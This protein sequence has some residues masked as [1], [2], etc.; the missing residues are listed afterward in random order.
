MRHFSSEGFLVPAGEIA[1]D[2]LIPR[3]YDPRIDDEL[4]FLSAT[5]HL[6]RIDSLVADGH[7]KHDHGKYIPKIYYGT[8]PIPYVRTSDLANWEI[9]ASPKHGIPEEVY[10]KHKDHQDVQPEDIL[11]VHEG[12]YLIGSA[13]MVTTY[14]GPMLYQHHL[15]KF[16]VLPTAPFGPYFF[17]AAL[18]SPTVQRQLRSR[19]FTADTIDSVVGRLG[20][21]V[22]P[23]PKSTAR[24]KR[25]EGVVKK[26]ITRR[27]EI[28][29]KLTFA[30]RGIDAFLAGENNDLEAVFEGRPPGKTEGPEFLGYRKAFLAFT[31]ENGGIR[32]D[33]LIPKYYDPSIE[34]DAKKYVTLAELDS[35]DRLREQK[36]VTLK[37]GDEIDSMNYGTGNIPFM[38]TSDLA[39]WELKREAKQSVSE[40]PV[41]PTHR[42]K[43]L[44]PGGH[45]DDLVLLHCEWTLGLDRFAALRESRLA[46]GVPGDAR[47][48]ELVGEHGDRWLFRFALPTESGMRTNAVRI[49]A[50]GDG[51]VVEHLVVDEDQRPHPEPSADSPE[52]TRMIL[53]LPGVQ[54]AMLRG[55]GPVVLGEREVPALVADALEPHREAPIVLISVDNATREPLVDPPELARRLAGMARVVSLS[56][57]GASRRLKDELVGRGFSEKFGCFHGGVRIL[58]PG[59][60]QGDDPYDHLLLLP[61]R[62]YPI[63]ER[64]RTER[65][66]GLFCE[67]I[68][69]DEDLRARLREVEAPSRPEPVRPAPPRSVVARSLTTPKVGPP[70][71]GGAPSGQTPATIPWRSPLAPQRPRA[72]AASPAPNMVPPAESVPGK[73]PGPPTI[74]DDTSQKPAPLSTQNPIPEHPPG[75]TS[76]P[77]P[78]S[79]PRCPPRRLRL[80]PPAATPSPRTCCRRS[81]SSS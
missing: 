69:E 78:A 71:V 15:A 67:M 4:E 35:I 75:L 60:Q 57:V 19:Q 22:I 61:V 31:Q 9:K 24:L 39:S 8:G 10:L 49:S 50:T 27:A 63:P 7:L 28:R 52:T 5:H 55:V 79:R 81:A 11:F 20:E 40:A 58:W 1:N 33:I 30:V 34:E 42:S 41:R 68:A 65:I 74:A 66:A 32:N 46:A 25:I 37:P 26:A 51:V 53:E 54:P 21:I 62:L 6:V 80:S 38:R 36:L 59:I 73:P 43:L 29:E 48:A 70:P 2:I 72:P 3:Y 18:E 77:I 44:I 16:R 45:L 12:T 64:T 14:D 13:A 76:A 17:L 47:A 23:Y 56:T